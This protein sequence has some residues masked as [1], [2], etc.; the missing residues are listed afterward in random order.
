MTTSLSTFEKVKPNPHCATLPLFNRKNWSR[1]RFGD[2]VEN[3][4]ERVEP[5]TAADENRLPSLLRSLCRP[6]VAPS[7]GLSHVKFPL[8]RVRYG[9][10]TPQ[11]RKNP[12]N[13]ALGRMVRRYGLKN[14]GGGE[15]FPGSVSFAC[16]P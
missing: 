16:P 12:G 11:N 2:V 5:S 9:S 4:N 8:G 6:S 14:P 7:A 15:T 10:G 1:F 13:I 3:V